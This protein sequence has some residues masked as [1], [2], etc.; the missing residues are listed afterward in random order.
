MSLKAGSHSCCDGDT[1]EYKQTEV[2]LGLC[3]RGKGNP[4]LYCKL[5]GETDLFTQWLWLLERAEKHGL[6]PLVQMHL[7]KAGALVPA[8]TRRAFKALAAR[9]RLASSIRGEALCEI[10][11]VYQDKDIPVLVLKGAALAHLV[12]PSPDLRPMSDIDLLIRRADAMRAQSALTG[13]GFAQGPGSAGNLPRD[14]HHLPTVTRLDQGLRVSVENHLD[15]FPHTRYYRSKSF[16]DLLD[17]AIPFSIGEID[18]RT[19][20]CEDLCWHVY[21]HAIG[22][23]LLLSRL[24]FIHLADLINLFETFADVIDWER[25]HRNHPEVTHILPQLHFLSPFSENDV[26]KLKI[27]LSHIPAGIAEDYLGWPRSATRNQS[28]AGGLIGIKRTFF[29]PEWWLRLY[30]GGNNSTGWFWRRYIRHP[31]HLL[32]WVIHFTKNRFGKNIHHDGSGMRSTHGI[33]D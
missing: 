23:P 31:F 10:L 18:A 26:A 3:A 28:R 7:N 30:Y 5:V 25:L 19:L 9:H 14:H 11:K 12:Y 16:A 22:P 29:P 32:E 13:L 6:A 15:I 21:R 20:G 33:P 8:N 17:E 4:Q 27:D 2:I 1:P 24:R